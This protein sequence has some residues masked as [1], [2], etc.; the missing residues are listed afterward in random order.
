[1]E[2]PKRKGGPRLPEKPAGGGAAA[3]QQQYA[4]ERGLPGGWPEADADEETAAT[5]DDAACESDKT[6]DEK[7]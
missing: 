1:M 4:Q 3:R 2:L 7:G 5:N 6:S